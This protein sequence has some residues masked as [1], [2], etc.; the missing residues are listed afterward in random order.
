[1]TVKNT[2]GS[3]ISGP[4]QVLFFGLP[5]NVSLVNATKNL[6]GTPF[7]T[8]PAVASLAPG[9]SATIAVK[10]KD[11]SNTKITFTPV[12]YSGSIN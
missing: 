1:V 11:P 12:I 10:F 7:I 2:S 5:V 9:Q 4:L 8:V 6:S 3:T